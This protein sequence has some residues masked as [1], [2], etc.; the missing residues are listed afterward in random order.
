MSHKITLIRGDGSGPELIE[1]AKRAIDKAMY[2]CGKEIEWEIFDA[3]AEI[4]KK[5]GTPLPD[6]VVESIKRNK[7]GLKGPVTTPLGKGF[8]SVNVELRKKLDLFV[9]L[10]PCKYYKGVKTR[11]NNPDNIDIVIIREN[12][13]DLYTGIEFENGDKNTNEV[14]K[15]I[16]DKFKN[17]S[18]IFPI[19]NDS[20]ISI[21]AISRYAT[22]R[23]IRYAFEYAKNNN[24]KSVTVVTK[25]NIMKFTDGLF[26]HTA[27]EISKEYPEI[28]FKHRLVDSLCMDLVT[29]PE[30]YDVLVLPN[31]YGDIVSDLCAGLVGGLGVVPGANIGK[32]YAVFE[33]VHGSAPEFKGKN[34]LNPSALILSGVLM[35]RFIKEYESANILE[36]AVKNVIEEGKYVTFDIAKDP[37]K[38]VGT[39]EMTDAILKEIE[40]IYRKI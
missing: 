20:A 17:N 2:V 23:I 1:Q 7:V 28:K 37:A 3:G 16:E 21:K 6:Y 18:E 10:R 19:R 13:E 14:I 34:L 11:I 38:A 25:S 4:A 12:T 35:L 8:R 27:E 9:N 30:N 39:T 40:K 33:A 31:L 5:E 15:F 36:N 24:R 22:E 32:D 26:M 29:V